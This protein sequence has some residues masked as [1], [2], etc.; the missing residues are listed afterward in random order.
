MTSTRL[1]ALARSGVVPSHPYVYVGP[2]VAV[3]APSQ[4]SAGATKTVEV[5]GA[6]R[7]RV[8]HA[9]PT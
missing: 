3:P 8:L 4:A 1:Q 6:P 9:T 7:L 2:A 5:R